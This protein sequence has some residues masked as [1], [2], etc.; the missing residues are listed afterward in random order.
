MMDG[1]LVPF[2]KQTKLLL[3]PEKMERDGAPASAE[4]E[5]RL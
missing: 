1:D 5:P 4:S 3:H 2:T